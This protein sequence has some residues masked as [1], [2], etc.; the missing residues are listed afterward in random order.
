MRI[1]QLT[2]L[3]LIFWV[4]LTRS[5][6]L[7]DLLLGTALSLV[8]AI[9]AMRSLMPEQVPLLPSRRFLALAGYMGR[10]VAM[11][12]ASAFQVASVVLHPRMPFNPIVIRYRTTLTRPV[13]RIALANSITLT[14]GAYSVDLDGDCLHIHCLSE[15]FARLITSGELERLIARVFERE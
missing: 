15:R 14:P 4:L 10:L 2:V 8:F 1:F 12:V 11:I 5:L 13:S 9:W 3:L 7:L 6:H